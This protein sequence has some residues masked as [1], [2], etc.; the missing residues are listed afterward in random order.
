MI[1]FLLFIPVILAAFMGFCLSKAASIRDKQWKD[2]V[3]LLED[4]RE[5]QAQHYFE[6][7]LM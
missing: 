6:D 7:V 3:A 4:G 2:Y 5:D 1:W